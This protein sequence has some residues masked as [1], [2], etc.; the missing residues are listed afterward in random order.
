VI[1]NH[2]KNDFIFKKLPS[3]TTIAL[4]HGPKLPAGIG[5]SVPVKAAHPRHDLLHQGCSIV[6]SAEMGK[7]LSEMFIQLWGW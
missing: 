2:T 4:N 6:V 3:S 5:Y 1:G 7:L